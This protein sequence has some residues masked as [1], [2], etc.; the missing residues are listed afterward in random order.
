[1]SSFD[2]LQ[3]LGQNDISIW[4][5]WMEGISLFGEPYGLAILWI[6]YLQKGN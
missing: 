1:M 5:V 6:T 4:K 3:T 2:I